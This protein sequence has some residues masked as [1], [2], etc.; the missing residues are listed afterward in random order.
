MFWQHTYVITVSTEISYFLLILHFTKQKTPK[1]VSFIHRISPAHKE[2][3]VRKIGV[4]HSVIVTHS[5]EMREKMRTT[6]KLFALLLAALLCISTLGINADAQ[7]T[8]DTVTVTLKVEDVDST[9]ISEQVTLTK[10]DVKRINSTFVVESGSVEIPVLTSENFTAANVLGKYIIDTSDAPAS[11]LTFSYGSPLYIKGQKTCDYFPYWSFRVNN[12]SPADEQTGYGYTSDRCPVQDGDCIVFFRQ[13]C[14]DQNAG[15]WGAYT[16]YSYFDKQTYQTTV[17]TPVS[18]TYLVDDGFGGT[19]SPAANEEISILK[20][21]DQVKKVKTDADGNALISFDQ[22]GT[23]TITSWKETNGIPENSHA[24]ATIVVTEAGVIPTEAPTP[25]PDQTTA[26]TEAPSQTQSPADVP[27][28]VPDETLTPGTPATTTP[29]GVADKSP[30]PPSAPTTAPAADVPP[31]RTV[32]KPGIPKKL[33]VSAA[34][35]VKAS[36]KKVKISWKKVS[37]AAGYEISVSKKNKKSFRTMAKTKKTKLTKKWKKGIYYI[38]V[39]SFAKHN[40]KTVYS[41]YSRIIRVN[42]R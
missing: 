18:I 5:A 33:T 6:K 35:K 14:Y 11:D 37:G 12:I 4:V 39:R 7:H 26:P 9:L 40:N 34:K 41:K 23:Y 28:A 22:T 27:T 29:A 30:A 19:P 31:N 1:K 8:T 10:D 16:K 25:T 38:K 21:A 36:S 2:N 20:Q 15:D 42:V 17:N 32:K 24:S 3:R 13:A